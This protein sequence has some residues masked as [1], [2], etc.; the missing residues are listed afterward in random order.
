MTLQ[1]V[2]G[3]QIDRGDDRAPREW[4]KFMTARIAS[5]YSDSSPWTIRRHVPP[6]GRRGRTLVY[7][8]ESV[9]AWMRGE[10]LARRNELP[11]ATTTPRSSA[12]NA[13]SL[14]RVRD[15]AKARKPDRAAVEPNK[16]HVAA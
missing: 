14:G 5:D 9:E 8:L 2:F 10:S 6:C 13:A 12:L 15:L 3:F 16:E 4:P 7:S 1:R 11:A